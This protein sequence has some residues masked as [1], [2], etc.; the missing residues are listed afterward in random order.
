MGKSREAS[1]RLTFEDTLLNQKLLR[2]LLEKL[3]KEERPLLPQEVEGY[4]NLLPKAT[5]AVGR[6]MH[7]IHIET[8]TGKP[9]MFGKLMYFAQKLAYLRDPVLKVRYR[10]EEYLIPIADIW[11][12]LLDYILKINPN[13]QHEALHLGPERFRVQ[14]RPDAVEYKP[15]AR[16]YH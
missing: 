14:A 13:A 16:D 7:F 1:V 12:T 10:R 8:K 11:N 3:I 2:K 15:S 4:L 5:L 6:G 9:I